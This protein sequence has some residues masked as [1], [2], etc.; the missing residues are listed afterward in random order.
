MGEFIECL[1][2]RFFGNSFWLVVE[3]LRR[4]GCVHFGKRSSN[5]GQSLWNGNRGKT[6]EILMCALGEWNETYDKITA[7]NVKSI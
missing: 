5:D 2:R 7:C 4:H 6:N 1:N 3:H